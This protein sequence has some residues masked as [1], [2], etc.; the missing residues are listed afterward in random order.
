MEKK[1]TRRQIEALEATYHGKGPY[2]LRSRYVEGWRYR[3]NMGGATS[4]MVSDLRD[5]GYL[6]DYQLTAAGYRVLAEDKKAMLHINPRELMVRHR[7]AEAAENAAVA[8]AEA[9]RREQAAARAAAEAQSRKDRL[10]KLRE[11]LAE[12]GVE[13]NSSIHPDDDEL[14]AF[15]GRVHEIMEVY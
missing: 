10:A 9:Q 12:A 15:A 6:D 11:L 3:T 1:L 8:A 14:L 7:E 13:L 4:R 5:R 2:A